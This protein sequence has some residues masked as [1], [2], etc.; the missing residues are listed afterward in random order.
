MYLRVCIRSSLGERLSRA[1]CIYMALIPGRTGN[2]K[3]RRGVF[4]YEICFSGS[5]SE[6]L[7]LPEMPCPRPAFR[8]SDPPNDA[9]HCTVT[10]L[11]ARHRVPRTVPASHVLLSNLLQP[12]SR[13]PLPASSGLPTFHHHAHILACLLRSSRWRAQFH[14]NSP[15]RDFGSVTSGQSALKERVAPTDLCRG[16]SNSINSIRERMLRLP[17]PALLTGAVPPVLHLS[18]PQKTPL[19]PS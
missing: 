16:R 17:K 2:R 13:V 10:C 6:I 4:T 14:A 9:A 3:K 15:Q 11:R 18:P 8:R 5:E 19:R 7:V 12:P 1:A